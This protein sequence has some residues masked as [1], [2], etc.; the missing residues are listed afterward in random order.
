MEPLVEAKVFLR[1][2]LSHFAGKRDRFIIAILK[3]IGNNN[4]NVLIFRFNIGKLFLII[5]KKDSFV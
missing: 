5:L 3:V 1:I 4:P 2:S